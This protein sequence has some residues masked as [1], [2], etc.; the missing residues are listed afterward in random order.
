[1]NNDYNEWYFM[2]QSVFVWMRFIWINLQSSDYAVLIWICI[3]LNALYMNKFLL[4]TAYQ[5]IKFY[6]TFNSISKN[7]SSMLLLAATQT[8][9]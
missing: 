2:N 1:M 9:S 7:W 6:S 8:T 3:H 5:N 4:Y